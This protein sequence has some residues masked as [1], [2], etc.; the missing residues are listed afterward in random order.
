MNPLPRLEAPCADKGFGN[1]FENNH[2]VNVIHG[3]MQ[4][5]RAD[6]C[7]RDADQPDGANFHDERK[8]RVAARA[9][10]ADEKHEVKNAQPDGQRIDQ[11][12]VTQVAQKLYENIQQGRPELPA[13]VPLVPG[14]DAHTG[15]VISLNILSQLWVIPR[16]YALKKLRGL[17][18]ELVDDWCR[19]TV[20]A[21][22]AFLR[23]LQCSVCLIADHEFVKQDRE[24]RIVSQG[25]TVFGIDLPDPDA[26]W[27]W[28][29]V[30]R[31]EGLQYLSKVLN[32]GAWQFLH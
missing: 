10:C 19:Q 5:E 30:P 11:H 3:Q 8:A 2:Q 25:S 27:I 6:E 7:G 9:Q 15:L 12:D 32:V 22:Y 29:I 26:L 1:F 14:I 4:N 18:E 28:N 16:S 24:G 20:E 31:G 23:S 21:H 17:E 13:S